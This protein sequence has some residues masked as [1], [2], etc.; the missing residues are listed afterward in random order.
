MLSKVSLDQNEAAHI[1]AASIH[2][3]VRRD[4]AVSVAVVDDAGILLHF[5]RM[6]H[7]R[8]HSVEL[9]SRKARAAAGSAVSTRMID[10]A[11]K[12]GMITNVDSVGWGGVPVTLDGG[13]AGAV[14]ISGASPEVDDEIASVA[15][16][17]AG[18]PDG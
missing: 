5:I 1:A 14:G 12:A 17:K 18:Q 3:A 9:A 15:A 11:L 8:V 7:A 16:G 2:E 4:V 10:M 13:C 6:D